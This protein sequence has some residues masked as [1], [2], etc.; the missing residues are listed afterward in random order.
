MKQLGIIA[1]VHPPAD[2]FYH[3]FNPLIIKTDSIFSTP[4]TVN[5]NF[6]YKKGG[7]L[8]FVPTPGKSAFDAVC[9]RLG[10]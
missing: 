9:G 3:K 4:V 7:I 10:K 5:Q 2:S 6:G 1:I 8:F